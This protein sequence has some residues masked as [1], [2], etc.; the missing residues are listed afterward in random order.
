MSRRK[1][2]EPKVPAGDL[3]YCGAFSLMAVTG[4]SLA[5]ARKN[6]REAN[7]WSSSHRI[8]GLYT[9]ELVA[10]FRQCGIK[11]ERQRLGH[12]RDY[13]I[14]QPV[15]PTLT[16]WLNN[17]PA[18]LKRSMC[19]VVLTDHFVMVNG[20]QFIDTYTKVPVKCDD[21]PHRR[22]RVLEVWKIM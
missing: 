17:R 15:R 9:H 13:K 16:E 10:S 18:E 8:R 1:L 3:A 2:K 6:I 19:L 7:S 14:G 4:K 11:I 21:A 5:A 12:R 22:A 20:N